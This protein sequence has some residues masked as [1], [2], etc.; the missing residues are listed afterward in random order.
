MNKIVNKFLLAGD[1]FM[2]GIHLKQTGCK[3]SAFGLFTKNK[4][5]I[6]KLKGT[7]DSVYIYQNKL[8]QACDMAYGDFKDLNRRTVLI[9]YY[10]IKY[11]ILL[12]I[13][14]TLHINVNFL[15]WFVNFFDENLLPVVL[16]IKIFLIKN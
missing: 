5:R 13:Q 1:T 15:Q 6:K 9:K 10:L 11:L 16:K 3:C 4:E 14:N 7:G 8:D 2:P 12:K